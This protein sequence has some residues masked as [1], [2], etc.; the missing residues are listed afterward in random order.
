MYGLP[1]TL[2]LLHTAMDKCIQHPVMFTMTTA[3]FNG[4]LYSVGHRDYNVIIH[5]KFAR[6]T[7]T[8]VYI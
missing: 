3:N 8:N 6:K 2:F 4:N 7:L 5:Y 1:I